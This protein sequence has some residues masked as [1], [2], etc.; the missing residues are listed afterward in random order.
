MEAQRRITVCAENSDVGL[1]LGDLGLDRLPEDISALTWLRE[2]R[3]FGG[4]IA[5]FLP[6]APLS[7]LELLE[8]GSM[9]CPFPGLD[10]M[11]GWTGVQALAII[12]PSAV[13]LKPVAACSALKHLSIWCSQGRIDLRHLEALAE[14]EAI[15]HLSLSGTQSDRFDVIAR[16]RRLKFVQLVRTNLTTLA[17]FEN[18]DQLT[19]LNVGEAPLTD[20]VPLAGLTALEQLGLNDTP[21]SDLSSLGS[22]PLLRSL[23]I[24]NTEVSDLSPLSRLAA[25]QREFNRIKRQED[26]FWNREGLER[27]AIHDSQIR[28]SRAV[29]AAGRIAGYRYAQHGGLIARSAARLQGATQVEYRR[30]GRHTSRAAR[31]VFAPPGPRRVRDTP[32]RSESAR[33][34]VFTS[35][36][37]YHRYPCFRSD[38]PPACL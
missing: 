29:G 12:T 14:L 30:D 31:L 20:L 17:G 37:G 33:A 5:N 26:P 23:D 36:A 22:L 34:S 10:F 3:M 7:N 35:S 21:V 2:L 38:A 11:S 27:L 28:R 25:C 8:V 24:S 1:Y 19:Y 16:W 18:L 9:N 6:L 32:G 15:E 4:R 13:D